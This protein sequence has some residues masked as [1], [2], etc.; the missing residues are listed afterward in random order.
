VKAVSA[1]GDNVNVRV[2]L[3]LLRAGL[4]LTAPI[5]QPAM[6]QISK[7]LSDRGMSL[8]LVNFKASALEELI[9][10]LGEMEII[11]D[12]AANGIM[13]TSSAPRESSDHGGNR[14]TSNSPRLPPRA[15]LPPRGNQCLRLLRPRR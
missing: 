8:D 3:A 5:P 13:S 10:S 7:S 2:P 15:L 6:K 9:E 1:A 14:W 12:N 11:V 4:K